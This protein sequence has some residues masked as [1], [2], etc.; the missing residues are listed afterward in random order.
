MTFKEEEFVVLVDKQGKR[1]LRR[2]RK[3]GRFHSH[4]G[5]IEHAR[6]IGSPP[7]SVI[8]SSTGEEFCVF[9]P[10]LIDY[11]M[12]MPRKS[13]IIY[14]KDTGI[15]LVW[16]DLFPGAEVLLG[17]VGT[18]A[19]LLAV[20]RQVGPRGRIVAYDVREDMLECAARNVRNCLGETPNL[21][22]RLGSVYEAI[23]ERGFQRA[24]LDV[25]EPWKAIDPIC[26]ALLPG[27][28]VCAYLP[29]ITQADAFVSAL[30]ERGSFTLIETMEVLLR[31]WHLTGR[32]VRPSHRMVGHTGFLIFARKINR[33]F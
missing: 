10:T 21:T 17:G 14:P 30:K 33:Q 16:A 3:G 23:E 24:L 11:T 25:P 7:G 18:G 15:I 29:S 13:G 32:S 6:I 28:I 19:L 5:Y 8:A 26:E 22:L 9:H 31:D 2:L 12:K 20:V 27:G 1:Y 4:R